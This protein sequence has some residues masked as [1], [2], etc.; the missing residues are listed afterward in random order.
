MRTYRNP[1]TVLLSDTLGL[2]LA[3]LEDVLV[4]ELAA[5]LDGGCGCCGCCAWNTVDDECVSQAATIRQRTQRV[6]KR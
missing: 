5:H 3:L 6:D 4:L 2:G 1:I